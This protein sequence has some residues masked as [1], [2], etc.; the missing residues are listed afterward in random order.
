MGRP[1]L[2]VLT[3]DYGNRR[4]H[5]YANLEFFKPHIPSIYTPAFT[6]EEMIR[7]R[8]VRYLP[9]RLVL[10][11][12]EHESQVEITARN[13]HTE[14]IEHFQARKVL[15]AAGAF[16]TAKIVLQSRGDHETRLPLLD[17]AISYVP[18]LNWRLIGCPLERS[19]LS[20]AQ[21]NLV[22]RGP[23]EPESI[24]ATYY[25]ITGPLRSDLLCDFPLALQ[26]NLAAA[27]YLIPAIGIMQVFY[28]DKPNRN[29][30]IRLTPEG[31]LQISYQPK[32]LGRL[33]R[34]MIRVFRRI[35]QWSAPFLCKYPVPGNSYHYAGCL[36]MQSSPGPYQ[37][38]AS[39][40]LWGTRRVHVVDS[41]NFTVLPSKNLTFTV[42]ENIK[43]YQANQ[44]HSARSDLSALVA[45]DRRLMP[46]ICKAVQ[47]GA[48]G[49]RNDS[50]PE[51]SSCDPCI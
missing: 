14:E 12:K 41:A 25:G 39:G 3:R 5:E 34:H 4:R 27:R 31:G 42:M 16:N 48:L 2:A 29:N 17:N 23:L 44:D 24:Q 8:K 9:N 10:Q 37:T 26:G 50:K 51:N 13:L 15:L 45:C 22:Y 49:R 43:G 30:G 38:D 11:Y 18:L 40:L 7:R 46:L 6:L 32:R 36:P 47:G 1:R 28:P 35:G 33:E 21:L 19:A 20:I